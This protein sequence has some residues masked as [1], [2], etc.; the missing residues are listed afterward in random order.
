VAAEAFCRY[1]RH[2]VGGALMNLLRIDGHL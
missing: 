1:D 2:R